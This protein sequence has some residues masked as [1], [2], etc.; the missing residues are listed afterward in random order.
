[1]AV[2]RTDVSEKILVFLRS[3]LQLLVAANVPSMLILF[4]L[5]METIRSSETLV[6]RRTTRRH[7]PEDCIL[8]LHS[9]V[10]TRKVRQLIKYKTMK[11]YGGVEA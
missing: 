3:V 7:I 10:V 11:M 2:L 9:V 8:K 6:L 4:T 1:V 5:M